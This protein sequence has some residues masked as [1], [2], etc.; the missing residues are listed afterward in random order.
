MPNCWGCGGDFAPADLVQ[1][2]QAQFC[3]Q[4]YSALYCR[5][6]VC[7]NDIEQDD[8]IVSAIDHR[9]YCPSCYAELLNHCHNCGH[10]VSRSMCMVVEGH[11][12]CQQCFD[13]IYTTCE[14]CG[15]ILHRHDSYS[16]PGNDR[17]CR[18]CFDDNCSVCDRCGD[19][20]WNCDMRTTDHGSFCPDCYRENDEWEAGEFDISDPHFDLVGSR[21]RYGV[22]LETSRCNDYRS[23]RGNTIWECKTDCSIEGREFVSPIL[24][25]DEGLMEILDFCTMARRKRWQ[26]NWQCG[27]HA[28]F[29]VSGEGW[30]VLRSIAYA[31]HKTYEMWCYLVSNRRANNAYCGSPDYTLEDIRDIS[32]ES[33]WDYFVGARDRFEFVN[34]RA[35]LVHGSFEVRFHDASLNPNIICNWIKLHARFMD[36]VSMMTLD[37]IDA[38]FGGTAESQFTAMSNFIGEEL[39]LEYAGLAEEY[40]HALLPREIVALSPPF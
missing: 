34:W 12:Y 22:E 35:Y 33:D 36:H 7:G 32:S 2:G 23:L 11:H 13:Q 25:G 37:E 29:D 28:H 5:C 10:E 20:H 1:R 27:Y 18:R 15:T 30:E 6:S 38:M 24:Y 14:H 31:Y 3:Q 21:R 8:A 9:P 40:G 16:T 26:I 4:C 17:Y 19:T 39:S